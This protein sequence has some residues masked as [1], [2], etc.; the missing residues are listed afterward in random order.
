[1]SSLTVRDGI[2]VPGE[3]FIGM[4][5]ISEFFGIAIYVYYREHVPPHFHALY[6]GQEAL[7]TIEHLSVLAG[8]LPPRAMGMVMEWALNTNRS[9][10]G[11]GS[12]PS[13]M[14]R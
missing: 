7:V 1:M 12:R 11:F 13:G 4:P 6:G 2:I 8:S 10:S 9:F 14:S 5:K 3:R